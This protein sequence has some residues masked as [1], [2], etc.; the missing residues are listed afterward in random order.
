M[1][2]SLNT[3]LNTYQMYVHSIQPIGQTIAVKQGMVNQVFVR[4]DIEL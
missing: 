4:L 3:Y 2:D 1:K